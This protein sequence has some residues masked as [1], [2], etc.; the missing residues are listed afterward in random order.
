[1]QRLSIIFSV[2]TDHRWIGLIGITL[3]SIMSG[4]PEYRYLQER[5]SSGVRLSELNSIAQVVAMLASVPP[6]S[7]EVRRSGPQLIQW[8]QTHWCSLE[9]FLRV[10]Q[11]RDERYIPIDG[12]RQHTESHLLN[13]LSNK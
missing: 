4:T 3:L 12:L 2:Q 5:F 9:P 1:M 6:P 10:I 7:R 8:Y 11:L 13:L